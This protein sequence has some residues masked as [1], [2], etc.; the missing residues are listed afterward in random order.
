MDLSS[1][2]A[3]TANPGEFVAFAFDKSVV[4]EVELFQGAP[5]TIDDFAYARDNALPFGTSSIPEPTSWFLVLSGSASVA[6]VTAV[7]KRRMGR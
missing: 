4:N 5:M 3:F 2:I 6:I 7:R 1:G